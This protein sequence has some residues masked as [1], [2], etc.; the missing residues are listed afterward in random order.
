MT[1]GCW[2]GWKSNSIPTIPVITKVDKVSSGKRM[3]YVSKVAEQTRL[4][5]H[6]FSCFSATTRE[7]RDDV[8]ERI[9]S[10]LLD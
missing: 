6:A 2:T 10:A 8:W 4:P 9:E 1:F 7:G 5:S 3:G